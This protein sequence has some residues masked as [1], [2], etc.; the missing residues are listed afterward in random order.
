MDDGGIH[1]QDPF[2][3]PPSL[4][5]PIRRF[6][7]R[8]SAGVTIWTAMGEQGPAGLTVSSI[9]VAEGQPPQI[10]GLVSDTTDLFEAIELT[11]R[12]VVHVVDSE[13]RRW[14]DGFA[15]LYPMPGGIFNNLRWNEGDHGPE[16]DE[17]PNR[18]TCRLIEILPAGYQ[19]LI[20]AEVGRIDVADLDDPLVYFRGRYRN[21]G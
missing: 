15:G 2:A 1:H 19:R 4:R 13:H 14:A 8:L 11:N 9:L 7:G 20:R 21:L 5:E 10:L 6:R 12:F 18:A 3:T 16:L 17:L